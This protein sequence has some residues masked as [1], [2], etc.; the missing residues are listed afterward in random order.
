MERSAL[1]WSGRW[2]L[3][4]LLMV[5]LVAPAHAQTQHDKQ[6]INALVQQG[7]QLAQ[8][9]N[10]AVAILRFK[11]ASAL[12]KNIIKQSKRAKQRAAHRQNHAKLLF[13]I[14]Q[15]HQL[16][17]QWSEACRYYVQS[18]HSN[19]S[20]RLHSLILTKLKVLRPKVEA[21]LRIIAK[22]A[23]AHV[24]WVDVLGRIRQGKTPVQWRV[25]PGKG[26][27]RV[28]A[29]RYRTQ[30]LSLELSARKRW[31]QKVALVLKTTL[32][33][34]RSF[35]SGATISVNGPQTYRGKTP[36]ERRF[37]PGHYKVTM[38]RKGYK[39]VTLDI[40][41]QG[42][43]SERTVQM[44]RLVLPPLPPPHRKLS[45][46]LGWT[47]AGLAVA[48]VVGGVVLAFLGE[49]AAQEYNNNAGQFANNSRQDEL[50]A[51]SSHSATMRNLSITSFVIGGAA[52]SLAIGMFAWGGGKPIPQHVPSP[53][54][55]STKTS[56]MFNLR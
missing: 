4:G 10:L 35:P 5:V 20:K 11:A 34:L 37:L 55:K 32:L 43:T 51:L 23:K 29:P 12:Y 27:L 50:F 22:P 16:N 9:G 38:K 48:G 26:E 53:P 46:G 49:Q 36:L 18:Y 7:K 56:T 14:A 28:R 41:L 54:S 25:L 6:E 13:I 52:T 1:V 40:Q 21:T 44:A 2:L 19:P 30:R 31:T 17:Q 42:E 33:R 39:P 15:A 3:F 45:L 24:Q 8:E 47:G